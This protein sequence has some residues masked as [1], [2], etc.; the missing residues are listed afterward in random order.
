[1]YTYI[2]R[3]PS[4][5]KIEVDTSIYSLYRDIITVE[6]LK[7]LFTSKERLYSMDMFELAFFNKSRQKE[8]L[9]HDMKLCDLQINEYLVIHVEAP[10]KLETVIEHEEIFDDIEIEKVDHDKGVEE[11]GDDKEKVDHDKGVEEVGDDKEKVEDDKGVEEVRDDKEKMED[12]KKEEA[13]NDKEKVDEKEKVEEVGNDKGVEEKE[14]DKQ[15]VEK[16]FCLIC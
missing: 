13:G 16:K 9:N 2:F 10:K 4:N 1:M 6:D 5:E 11:V 7:F 15:K 12:D 3:T 8:I 14:N